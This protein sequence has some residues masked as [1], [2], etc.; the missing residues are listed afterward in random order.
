MSNGQKEKK[1]DS[2]ERGLVITDAMFQLSVVPF[3]LTSAPVTFFT[4]DGHCV[5]WSALKDL[6]VLSM[7]RRCTFHILVRASQSLEN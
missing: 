1:W 3:G 2:Q 6:F 7:G 5:S 4:N